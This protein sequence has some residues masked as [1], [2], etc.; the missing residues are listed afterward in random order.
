MSYKMYSKPC[1]GVLPDGMLMFMTHSIEIDEED[2][3][4]KVL[5]PAVLLM[6]TV[7]K[8][9]DMI[10]FDL[11]SRADTSSQVRWQGPIVDW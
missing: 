9:P 1:S 11:P 10:L 7:L 5:P 8:F 2:A 6:L 3:T 4:A